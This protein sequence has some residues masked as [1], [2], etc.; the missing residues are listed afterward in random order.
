MSEHNVPYFRNLLGMYRRIGTVYSVPYWYL[1]SVSAKFSNATRNAHALDRAPVLLVQLCPISVVRSGNFRLGNSGMT[2]LNKKILKSL[3]YI[4]QIYRCSCVFFLVMV[5]LRYFQ[6]S[7]CQ[8]GQSLSLIINQEKTSVCSSR[9]FFSFRDHK[10]N[11][12]LQHM[13]TEDPQRLL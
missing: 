5:N 11:R 7:Y 2:F 6:I 3:R 8:T 4:C 1:P 9:F 13:G 10:N 12:A